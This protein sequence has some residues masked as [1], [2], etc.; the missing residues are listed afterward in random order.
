MNVSDTWK[1]YQTKGACQ[2]W[3]CSMEYSSFVYVYECH[4]WIMRYM[5]LAYRRHWLRRPEG[6]LKRKIGYVGF[7]VFFVSV[8]DSVFFFKTASPQMHVDFITEVIWIVIRIQQKVLVAV[9]NLAPSTLP[10]ILHQNRVG[11]VLGTRFG[12][13]LA[14]TRFIYNAVTTK[15]PNYHV[16]ARLHC[17]IIT[18]TSLIYSH[19]STNIITAYTLTVTIHK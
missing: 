1:L 19:N 8:F 10:T 6:H 14:I 18:E 9:P 13:Y 11:R 4:L 15:D 5:S 16:I 7:I 12:R 17:I 2:S 3:S